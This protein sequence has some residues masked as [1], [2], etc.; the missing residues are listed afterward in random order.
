MAKITRVISDLET[1]TKRKMAA[2]GWRHVASG[3]RGAG[4]HERKQESRQ[5]GSARVATVDHMKDRIDLN[6][7]SISP[8]IGQEMSRSST[9][10]D[11]CDIDVVFRQYFRKREECYIITLI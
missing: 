6:G 4:R 10:I 7:G 2:D 9:F 8:R 11:L 1:K 5:A 3:V